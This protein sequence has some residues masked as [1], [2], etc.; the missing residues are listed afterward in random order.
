MIAQIF[1]NLTDTILVWPGPLYIIVGVLAGM[2]FGC[3]PGLNGPIL[4][5]LL[6]PITIPLGPTG[7]MILTG[8]IMGAVTCGGSIP[9]IL[10]NTPG[11]ETNAATCIEGFPLAQKGKAALALGTAAVSSSLGGILGL[12]MLVALLPIG[13]K[14]ILAFSY[15]E[16]FMLTLLGISLVVVVSRG[17]VLRGVAAGFIGLMV[18]YIGADTFTGQARYVFGIKFLWGGVEFLPCLIGMFAVAEAYDMM[19]KGGVIAEGVPMAKLGNPIKTALTSFKLGIGTVIKNFGLFLS[20]CVIGFVIGVIPGVG[21]TVATFVSY[22]TA[23]QTTK[24]KSNFGKGEIRGI[25][26]AE[27]ANDA[28]DGGALLPTLLFGLPG[29]S[30]MAVLLGLF[31]LHGITPGLQVMREDFGLVATL[32]NSHAIGNLLVAL[33]ALTVAPFIARLTTIRVSLIAPVVLSFALL[34]SLASTGNFNNVLLAI[35]FGVLGYFFKKFGYSRVAFIIAL[36]LGSS[37]EQSYRQ[38]LQTMGA[39]GFFTRPIALIM[40]IVTILAIIY[41]F[42]MNQKEETG[43]EADED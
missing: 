25:V 15:P 33:I 43:I 40:F 38:T 20:S 21:G 11:T 28:K 13:D 19:I 8:A 7:A 10:I 18:T 27:S 36:V 42:Y 24:D 6:I 37:M 1:S 29:S 35:I 23:I 14:L 22:M 17:N 9:A 3:I 12:V 31:L 4:I 2:T 34:G 26:A 41:G 32:I 30:V 16:T 5:A 39:K